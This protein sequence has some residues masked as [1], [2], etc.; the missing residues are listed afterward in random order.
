MPF[1]YILCSQVYFSAFPSYVI[2]CKRLTSAHQLL[3][4]LASGENWQKVGEPGEGISQGISSLLPLFW[5]MAVTEYV[6]NKYQLLL[7]LLIMIL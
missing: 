1:L 7:S 6:G 2:Y 4:D 3:I 5:T